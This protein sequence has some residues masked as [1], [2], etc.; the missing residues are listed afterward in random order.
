[1]QVVIVDT[2]Y[3][4]LRSVERATEAAAAGVSPSIQV[5]RSSDPEA[6]RKA[7]ALIFPGQGAFRDCRV[8]LSDAMKQAL[9]ERIAAGTPFLGICV[10]LQLLFEGSDEAPGCAG[11]GLFKG[12]VKRLDSQGVK[13]PHMG[14]NQL[15][16]RGGSHPALQAAGGEGTWVYFV[17]SYH[18]VPEDSALLKA[19]VTYGNNR[20][21][22]AVAQDNVLATQF[23]PEKSQRAGQ[24]LLQEF[25]RGG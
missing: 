4:N 14:W 5:A 24:L 10:G 6:M 3:G 18:A 11:L 20:V 22:A 17:H 12:H 19:Q 8:A 13:I 2:G 25:L 9:V 7:N 15:E 23:H 21:T 1:M 16:L